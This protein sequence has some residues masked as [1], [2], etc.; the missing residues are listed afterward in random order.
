MS[1]SYRTDTASRKLVLEPVTD[2]ESSTV[3]KPDTEEASPR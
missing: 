1:V 3:I 2:S